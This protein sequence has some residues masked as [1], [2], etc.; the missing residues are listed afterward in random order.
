MARGAG[1]KNVVECPG[2]DTLEYLRIATTANHASV[3]ISKVAAGNE[4]SPVVPLHPIVLRERFKKAI[5]T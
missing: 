4:H 2:E 5:R 1:C 3:I